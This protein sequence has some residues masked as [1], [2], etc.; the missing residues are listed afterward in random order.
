MRI[1]RTGTTAL[2]I[3]F[4][5]KLFPVMNENEVLLKNSGI[6]L[7]GLTL[8]GI[9][10]TFT[11]QYSRGL[12]ETIKELSSRVP[13]LSPIEKTDFSCYGAEEYRNFLQQ[14]QFKTIILC[15]IEAHV[16]V[17]QTAVDLK[18]AGYFPV[19]ITDCISSRTEISK[20]GAVERFRHENI[21]M[22]TYESI[23][24]EL[25]RSAKN[26]AFRGISRLVK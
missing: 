24:F 8:L 2:F 13:H 4:Q 16:C 26:D 22:S 20:A 23:L 17:L 19:I 10:V 3:D 12:G 25:T 14:H 5:E 9:S 6:L 1:T 7:E 15:G 11:Q 18:E 21:M